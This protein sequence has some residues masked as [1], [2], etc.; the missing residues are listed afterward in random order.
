MTQLRRRQKEEII[1]Q[2]LARI[3]P[4]V[5]GAAPG[6]VVG[7][8]SVNGRTGNVVIA[9]SDIP[10]HHTTHENGGS[11]QISV[12][13]LLGVLGNPQPPIIGATGTT[14]VAGN[15]ARLTDARTPLAH[16]PSHKSGGSD[17]IKL[18]ELAA[19]TDVTTLNAAT[20]QHGLLPK[21]SGNV[22]DVLR[23]DGTFGTAPAGPSGAPVIST[24]EV[25]L[26]SAPDAR[27]NGHVQITGL[28]GLTVGKPVFAQQAPGPYTGKGTR[29]DEA[30]M[31]GLSFIGRVLSATVIDLYWEAIHR[32]RGNYKVNYLVSS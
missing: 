5:A 28:A 13:G 15:D 17:S 6:P 31:D 27:R 16:A 12:A 3:S 7:V 4:A 18:D 9:V 22:S 14:A 11:D 19:P 29:A 2:T 20:T 1:R 32:V 26:G 23:G 24:A 30:E 10:S 21:L 8:A 25:S